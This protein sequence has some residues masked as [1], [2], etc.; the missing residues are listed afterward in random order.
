MGYNKGDSYEE[1]IF[2]VCKK[3]KYSIRIVS[4]EGQAVNQTLYLFI[5]GK[6]VL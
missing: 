5:E 6:V 4:E 1:E 3:R 2:E